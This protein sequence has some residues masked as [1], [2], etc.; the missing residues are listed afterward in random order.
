[1]SWL[2]W[3]SAAAALGFCGVFGV[4]LA[5][6]GEVL[7]NPFAWFTLLLFLSVLLVLAWPMGTWLAAIGLGKFPKN[8]AFYL[9]YFHSYQN[10]SVPLI[11]SRY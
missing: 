6:S 11:A 7:M 5:T 3:C 1:M 8:L 2:M 4:C 9:P 10:W